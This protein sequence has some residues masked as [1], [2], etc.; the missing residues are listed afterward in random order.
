VTRPAIDAA[1][2]GEELA[3]LER[4]VA[5]GET[6]ELVSTLGAMMKGPR[7]IGAASVEDRVR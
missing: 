4:L 5:E 2:L 6:L 1:W 7:R 3:E